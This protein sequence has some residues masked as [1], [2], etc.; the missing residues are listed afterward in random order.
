MS[1]NLTRFS[2]GDQKQLIAS[3]ALYESAKG[4]RREAL[5]FTSKLGNGMYVGW[6]TETQAKLISNAIKRH[7]VDS[8]IFYAEQ[9]SDLLLSKKMKAWT[10]IAE[11]Q[12]SQGDRKAATLSF[13]KAINTF[14]QKTES[15]YF[16]FEIMAELALGKSL[17]QNGLNT[18][19]NQVFSSAIHHSRTI[20]RRRM[21]DRISIKVNI[22]N[23]LNLVKRTA[24]AKKLIADAYL[25]AHNFPQDQQFVKMHQAS[26]LS[27]IALA[28]AKLGLK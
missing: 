21:Q 22:A 16:N 2:Y 20:P 8:A 6:R 1:I 24:E 18:E 5:A 25:E 19:G 10:Q 15:E 4:N 9:F 13:T 14:G 12:T 7:D 28:A 23:A 11:L 27:E 17:I 3:N 26:L